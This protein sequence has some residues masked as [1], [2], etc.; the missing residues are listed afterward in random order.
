MGIRYKRLLVSSVFSGAFISLLSFLIE[1][2]LLKD[3]FQQAKQV[4]TLLQEPRIPSIIYTYGISLILVGFVINF[5]YAMITKE[6]GRNLKIALLVGFLVGYCVAFP[7][8]YSTV[9]W[10]PMDAS[11]SFWV[12]GYLWI[13]SIGAGLIAY[14]IYR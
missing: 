5:I 14:F 10:M 4:G 12:M 6:K 2:V 13:G 11:L 7:I 1:G 3:K 8:N 9:S